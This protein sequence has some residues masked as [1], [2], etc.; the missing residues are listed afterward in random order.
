MANCAGTVQ[1]QGTGQASG[2]FLAMK[3]ALGHFMLNGTQM[4]VQRSCDSGGCT[5][6]LTGAQFEALEWSD[7]M[8]AGDDVRI[9]VSGDGTCFCQ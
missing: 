7:P 6:G 5:F 8:Q 9:S 2:P 3:K 1:S 4:C